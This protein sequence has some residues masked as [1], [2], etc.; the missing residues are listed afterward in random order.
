MWGIFSFQ[1]A[2][3]ALAL[4]ALMFQGGTRAEAQ[5][6][7]RWQGRT[8]VKVLA[9]GD[10]IPGANGAVFGE[11]TRFTLRDRTLHIVAGESANRKGLFRWRDGQL[12][13]LVY[14][15]TMAPT[16]S[17]F[18]TVHFTTDETE[19]ALNFVG[20]VF[21]GRPG[22]VYGLFEWRDGVI[23]RVFD[24]ATP[25]DGKSLAGIGYPVRVGHQVVG[26]S[27][28]S[29]G[30]VTKNGILRWDG[31]HLHTVIQTGDDL[32]GSL[33]GFTG[34]PGA[35]QIAFDGENVGFVAS[36]D[37]QGRGP[38]G[39]YRTVPGGGIVK[40]ID[41]NDRHPSG[42]TYAARGI[43]FVNVDVDGT[44]SFLGVT[45]MVAAAGGNS[46]YGLG[47]R[48]T[49][50]SIDVATGTFG[51]D[52]AFEEVLPYVGADGVTR[53]TLDGE[54]WTNIQEVDGQ[55]DDVALL[56]RLASGRLAIYA[57][58]GTGVEPP[59]PPTVGVPLVADGKLRLRF[60]SVAGK[61][62]R[63]EFIPALGAAWVGR[64]E[65]AGTGKE[66]EFVET[67]PEG[68]AGFYRIA[69]LP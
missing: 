69:L 34:H 32:P 53:T 10:P 22:F 48:F 50:G 67:L 13:K 29:E 54:E 64:G 61:T 65:L 47:S 55:G 12:T 60:P 62:Y 15:D 57:A 45:E 20:E 7:P 51:T 1:G 58:I 28:F 52:G 36:D 31:A 46:F 44:N 11:I 43:T 16:G 49:G 23:T 25:V 26:S 27:Q 9:K 56:V 35:Y 42:K 6:N 19:G 14:T 68:S 5:A 17:P 40:L 33:G 59:A 2:V 30:G 3:V 8:F 37:L 4:S 41:G 63:I 21:Y 18:D 39:I 38:R 24:S 66:L